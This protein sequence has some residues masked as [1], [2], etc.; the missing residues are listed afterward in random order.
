MAT[1]AEAAPQWL[2]PTQ[3]SAAGRDAEEPRVAVSPGGEAVAVWTR[4]D[5]AN[6]IVQASGRPPGG[7]WSPAVDISVAGRNAE[8]PDV[9]IDSAGNATA[10]WRR[11][12]GSDYVLQTATRPAGGSWQ[13]PTDLSAAGE[14][15]KEPQLAVGPAGDAVA[16]WARSDGL[17][18]IVQAAARPAGGGWQGALPLSAAGRDAEAPQVAVDPSGDAV[19]VWSRHDGSRDIVQAARRRGGAWEETRDLS[20]PGQNAVEPQ[21]DLDP[22]GDAVAVWSR[23]DGVRNVV[24]A[25]VA[26][27]GGLWAPAVT[28]SIAGQSGEEPR[29]AIDSDGDAVAVWT[30]RIFPSDTIQASSIHVGGAWLPAVTLST[31]GE[32][33]EEPRVSTDP[34]GNAVAVWSRTDSTPRV[35]QSSQRPAGGDWVLQPTLLSELGANASEPEVASDSVGNDVAIWKRENGTNTVIQAIAHDGGSPTLTPIFVPAAGTVRQTLAFSATPFDVWSPVGPLQWD[36]GDSG[37]ALGS[38]VVHSFAQPGT[39]R[40]TVAAADALGNPADGAGTVQIYP[41]PSAG[42]NVRIRRGKGLLTL[43]CPS[44][45][46]CEGSLRMIAPVEVGRGERTKVKRRRIAKAIFEIPGAQRTTIRVP[47]SSKGLAAAKGAG[48][49]GLKAQ[50]TGPG[51]R[52]RI[53][54]LFAKR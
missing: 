2:S 27:G 50:L 10:V 6:T 44:P 26:I 49:R 18:F 36:F 39:Y 32:D 4:F 3:L 51:V 15:A 17:D 28:L 38:T 41:K 11:H 37:T 43:R 33:A 54:V 5:G 12:D 13:A 53:V 8:E 40:V 30:R 9:G 7:A 16:I 45:A 19:A 14:P 46:G 52:H 35:I 22:A 21:V 34:L 29:V 24:Q 23:F 42:R 47:I 31:A 20:L 25:A 48:R 1:P